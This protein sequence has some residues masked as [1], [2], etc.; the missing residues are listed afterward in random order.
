MKIDTI[1]FIVFCLAVAFLQLKG[2]YDYDRIVN[3]KKEVED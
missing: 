1:I 3:A 2:E